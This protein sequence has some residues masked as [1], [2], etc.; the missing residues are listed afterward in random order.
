[1]QSDLRI[2]E[3]KNVLADMPW[4]HGHRLVRKNKWRIYVHSIYIA[5]VA[6]GALV[7]SKHDMYLIRGSVGAQDLFLPIRRRIKCLHIYIYIYFSVNA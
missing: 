7:E 5:V 6:T 3:R 1:M 2:F 4:S